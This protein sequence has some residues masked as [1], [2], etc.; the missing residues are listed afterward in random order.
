M[1]WV[2]D[3]GRYPSA[4]IEGPIS[5]LRAVKIDGRRA[6]QIGIIVDSAP[7]LAIGLLSQYGPLPELDR[8]GWANG[9]TGGGRLS[10]SA[11]FDAEIALNRMMATRI[12]SHRTVGTGSHAFTT[13]CAA[14][15]INGDYTSF[16]IL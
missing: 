5:L 15:L 8:A 11:S 7:A 4:S 9:S 3:F 1:A 10:C 6:E 13:T 16:R 12:V 14:I 2:D